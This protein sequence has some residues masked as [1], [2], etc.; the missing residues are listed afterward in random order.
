MTDERRSTTAIVLAYRNGLVGAA[1][2]AGG[3]ARV[4]RVGGTGA[5]PNGFVLM[6]MLALD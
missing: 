5:S 4:A 2:A 6:L 1:S 3:A